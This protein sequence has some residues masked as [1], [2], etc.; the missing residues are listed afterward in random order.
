MTTKQQASASSGLLDRFDWRVMAQASL[1]AFVTYLS[2]YAFRKP[3]TAATYEGRSVLGIDYK[4]LLIVLQLIGYT[5]SK[6]IGVRFVS[7][8]PKAS[9]MRALATLMATAWLSLLLFAIVP[10]PYN[11]VC[12]FL[13]GL[14]LGMIW[15][16][17]FS[18]LEG[19]R[20]T[21]LLGGIMASS[22][23]VSSGL[24]K[25]IGVGVLVSARADE[26]WMPFV[27]AALFLPLLL[28]GMYLLHRVP[29]PS[30]E[31]V[32]RRSARDPMTAKER[33]AF[34]GQFAPGILSAVLLYV[35]LTVFRDL[36]DNFAVEIWGELG[37]SGM[38]QLLV[39]SE[40]PIAFSVLLLISLMVLMHNN[41]I[42]FHTTHFICIA[43]GLLL[44]GGTWLH[45]R[46]ILGSIGWMIVAGFSMYFPY[47]C[48]H[49]L[50]FERWIAHYRVR[51][52][53][54]YLMY[55][56]D[57]F[58]YLGS[59]AVLLFRNFSDSGTGWLPF[60]S[61]SAGLVSIAMIVLGLTS[62]A[63]FRSMDR[64]QNQMT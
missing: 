13:N 35:A 46:H 51:G 32:D 27:T 58:G 8:L 4:I 43:C 49:T 31:D 62:L 11:A 37:Y 12:M 52:N 41:R 26:F 29:L 40:I 24:V 63:F 39:L 7:S 15:G 1:A 14:P 28:T 55:L 61:W 53:I 22:F 16:V 44:F 10:Y 21:E 23:I 2:M 42:A 59:T 47:M 33:K 54:G 34:F 6:F 18:Y 36:R 48:Y 3:F 30:R 5:L 20:T 50:Y 64:W 17:V 25:N 19:R 9:R 45:D 38:P 60:F 56:S 57:S